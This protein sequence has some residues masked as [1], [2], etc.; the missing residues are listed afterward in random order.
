MKLK[1]ENKK[2]IVFSFNI[3][4]KGLTIFRKEPTKPKPKKRK[5]REFRY[6]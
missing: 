6:F 3:L 4:G 1:M 5:Q 2:N